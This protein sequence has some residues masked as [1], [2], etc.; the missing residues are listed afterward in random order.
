MG[1]RTT[2]HSVEDL[3]QPDRK[4]AE[5]EPAL[6]SPRGSHLP[7]ISQLS[8][9][10]PQ[11][12]NAWG[13]VLT[14]PHA[15]PFMLQVAERSYPQAIALQQGIVRQKWV[16]TLRSPRATGQ[17][18]WWRGPASQDEPRQTPEGAQSC[19]PCL[20]PHRVSCLL[21]LCTSTL[22]FPSWCWQPQKYRGE[23]G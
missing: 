13:H 4:A 21:P 6:G 23:A 17:V 14:V 9:P 16:S 22:P 18:K 2:V 7:S 8:G 3:T 15:Q 12:M 19:Q 20:V 11:Y 1:V 10:G 5:E